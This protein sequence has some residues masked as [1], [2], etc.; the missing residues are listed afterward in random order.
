VHKQLSPNSSLSTI[1]G[2]EMYKR[3]NTGQWIRRQPDTVYKHVMKKAREHDNSGVDRK[4]RAK[5]AEY[6]RQKAEA[7]R[8]KTRK[9]QER[10]VHKE[11]AWDKIAVIL[12]VEGLEKA[13]ADDLKKQVV[14]HRNRGK[15][16]KFPKSMSKNTKPQNLAELKK[17][18]QD[19]NYMA[20]VINTQ[21]SEGR[22]ADV[23]EDEPMNGDE[24]ETDYDDE[25]DI[26]LDR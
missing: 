14:W 24:T 11:A 23:E 25:M 6:N 4:K 10:R 26:D 20:K 2:L 15:Y 19:T 8:V 18:L 12:T 17:V 13:L 7:G 9:K 5:Q 21:S 16:S 3:N 1:N 22:M